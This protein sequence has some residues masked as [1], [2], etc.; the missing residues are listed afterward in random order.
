MPII[1]HRES[2]ELEP[3]GREKKPK[4][5]KKKYKS[6]A[7]IVDSDSSGDD[8]KHKHQQK[9]QQKVEC[10]Y[11]GF[12]SGWSS[13]EEKSSGANAHT[14]QEC[15]LTSNSDEEN[16][17]GSSKAGHELAEISNL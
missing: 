12:S 5:K 6:A 16:N 4:W 8:K 11:P 17:S 13:E 15:P 9:E 2:I 14:T 10:V 7:V 3:C 1:L